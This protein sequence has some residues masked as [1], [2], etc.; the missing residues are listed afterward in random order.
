MVYSTLKDG[1]PARDPNN[2]ATWPLQ[3]QAKRLWEV[4]G[5][6]CVSSLV[7]TLAGQFTGDVT[8]GDD[9]ASLTE[10][11]FELSCPIDDWESAARWAGW[12]HSEGTITW[13]NPN[14]FHERHNGSAQ[15]LCEANNIEPHQREVYEHWIVSDWL[16]DMLEAHGEKIDKDFSGLTVWARTTTGQAV[17]ADGVIERIAAATY[18]R[19]G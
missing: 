6:H 12:K 2:I 10:Q 11:A 1:A 4:E 7:H 3:E 17:Y 15:E 9:F 14:D 18:G 19:E 5:G 13:I 16:A 8:M